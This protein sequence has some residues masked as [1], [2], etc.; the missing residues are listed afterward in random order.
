MAE[1][2]EYKASSGPSDANATPNMQPKDPVKEY[3][4]E[5]L[6]IYRELCELRRQGWQTEA[7]DTHFQ[8]QHQR[9]DNADAKG[10]KVFFSIMRD[11]G[12][13][14]DKATSILTIQGGGNSRP[15]ILDLCMGPGGFSSAALYRNPFALVR[16]ITLL[17]GE[18]GT[19]ASSISASHPE[20]A[21]FSFDRPF[22]EQT[23]DLVFCDGQVLRTHERLEGESTGKKSE[24]SRLLTAQLVLA[25]QRIRSGGTMVIL[26]H[27][28]DAWRSV[29]L[30]YTFA[31]FSDSVELFK[32]RRAHGS[33]SL[34]YL[35]AKGV[36]PEREATVKAVRRWKEKW[37]IATFGVG[38]AGE[39]GLGDEELEVVQS[40]GEDSEE[41]VTKIV[42]PVFA[43]QAEALKRAPWMRI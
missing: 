4:L 10:K 14:L 26:L 3:L 15:A 41:K 1:I 17:A 18:M 20:A 36:R 35:I 30:M 34:F 29:F 12:L 11:I 31:T 25:L 2:S 8:K 24:A 23:F 33:P 40:G 42:Q 5:H 16:A 43:V 6:P 22:L 32:P 37:T 7:G 38:G 9:A 27:K 21:S 19:P 28:A 39:D 13:E